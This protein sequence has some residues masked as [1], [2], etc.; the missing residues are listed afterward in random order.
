MPNKTK[1]E[2]LLSNPQ[3]W[4]KSAVEMRTLAEISAGE[5]KTSLLRIATEYD[6]LAQ[7][8]DNRVEGKPA[9]SPR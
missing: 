9:K 6:L 1:R 7:R 5:V 3:H 4:R 8:A 2:S